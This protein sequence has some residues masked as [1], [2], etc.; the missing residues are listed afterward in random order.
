MTNFKQKDFTSKGGKAYKFQFPGMRAASQISDRTKNKH[1]IP[2]EEKLGDE[3]M[4]HVIV[5]PKLSWDSFGDNKKEFNE[6][7]TAAY[8]FL[9][10]VD[11]DEDEGEENG[12][13]Q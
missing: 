7:I 2:Q 10:G 1:G 8:H 6:V 3:M 5:Q 4:K 12:N 11:E 13:D 9:E